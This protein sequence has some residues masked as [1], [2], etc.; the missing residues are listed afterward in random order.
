VLIVLKATFNP[1]TSDRDYAKADLAKFA[2]VRIELE[3]TRAA[4]VGSF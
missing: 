1:A 4:G 3:Q 2:D